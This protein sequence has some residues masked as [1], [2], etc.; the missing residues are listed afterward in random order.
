[1]AAEEEAAQKAKGEIVPEEKKEKAN[2]GLS[3]ALAKDTNT[4]NVYNGAPK[5]LASVS[6]PCQAYC[7]VYISRQ[8][9]F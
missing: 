1:V 6:H 2:F 7:F 4:G 5:T 9:S 3:G 8:V